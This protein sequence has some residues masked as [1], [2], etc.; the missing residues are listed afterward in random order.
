MDRYVIIP[1][2]DRWALRELGAVF[3]IKVEPTKDEIIAFMEGYMT[4]RSGVVTIY[5][6]EET[7]ESERR[8]EET[9]KA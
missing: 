7:I 3:P 9:A 4:C 8:F 2:D 6:S 5:A 1:Q